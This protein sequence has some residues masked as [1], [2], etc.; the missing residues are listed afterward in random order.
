MVSM[1]AFRIGLATIVGVFAE[2]FSGLNPLRV[3]G[4]NL[5]LLGLKR[6]GSELRVQDLGLERAADFRVWR[7]R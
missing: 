2:R 7:D 3:Q 4:S 5:S 6:A 1:A